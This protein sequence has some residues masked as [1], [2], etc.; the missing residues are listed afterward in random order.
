MA[1]KIWLPLN[2]NMKNQGLINLKEPSYNGFTVANDGKIGK[3]YAGNCV[4]HLD[5][6]ILGNEWTVAFW[7]KKR[8]TGAWSQYNDI[9]FAKNDNVAADSQIYVSIKQYGSRLNLGLNGATEKYWYSYSFALDTWYHIAASFDGSRF[10]LYLNGDLVKSGDDTSSYT[11]YAPN[12]GLGTR[13]TATDGTISWG[14]S[15]CLNDVRLYDECLSDKQ[16]KEISKGLICHYTFN[17]SYVEENTN[18]AQA[19]TRYSPYS[20]YTTPEWDKE[21]NGYIRYCP[22]GWSTGYNSGTPDATHGYH[23]HWVFD[24]TGKLIMIFPNL[25]NTIGQRGRWLGISTGLSSSINN[26][27]AGEKYTI[28]WWQKTDNLKLTPDAGIFYRLTADAASNAFNDG[29]VKFGYNTKLNTWEFMSRTFTR[30]SNYVQNNKSQA[31]YVYGDDS[32]QE[33][34]IWVKDVQVQVGDHATPYAIGTRKKQLYEPDV[35][36]FGYN[37][38]YIDDTLITEKN[39]GRYDNAVHRD[40]PS[41]AIGKMPNIFSSGQEADEITLSCWYKTNTTLGV[42]KNLINLGGNGFIRFGPILDGTKIWAYMYV[43]SS[44]KDFNSSAFTSIEDN[45]W[46]HYAFTFKNGIATAYLDGESVGTKDCTDAGTKLIYNGNNNWI[47][48]YGGN[49]DSELVKGSLSDARIYVT[50]LSADDIKKL[51]QSSAFVDNKNNLLT[52][53]IKEV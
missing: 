7:A 19:I 31:L 24:E 34:T 17:N 43:N 20:M 5:K 15:V 39:G 51:Y 47:G 33:G 41:Y 22:G 45:Q 1:L 3:T 36:G 48:G 18:L 32:K 35:S 12:I 23:A 14:G 29:D 49:G 9:L 46:H 44:Y 13:S 11:T 6:E 52:Y 27:L 53:E 50:A 28:S 10:N 40:A 2:G 4:Y 30:N 8:S 21:L 16:V 25:N 42:Q 26:V 37:L 38:I